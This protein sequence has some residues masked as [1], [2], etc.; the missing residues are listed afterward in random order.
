MAKSMGGN[1]LDRSHSIAVAKSGSIYLVGEYN[2][3]ADFDPG[4]ATFTLFPHPVAPIFGPPSEDA[5]I[6]KL[7]STGNFRWAFGFA[8][9]DHGIGRSVA[10]DKNE[11]VYFA[12]IFTHTID[13]DPGPATFNMTSTGTGQ[14]YD[15][16]I[17]KLDSGGNF[18]WAKQFGGNQG[19]EVLAMTLDDFG[20]IYTCGIF[21]TTADFDPGPN[22]FNLSVTPGVGYLDAFISKLDA[23][24]NFKWAKQIGGLKNELAFA[25]TSDGEGNVI[26]T[27]TFQDSADFD[28]GPLVYNLYAGRSFI[29]KLDSLGNFVWAKSLSGMNESK[30]VT[31]DLNGNVIVGGSFY[32]SC[33]F[34]PGVSNYVLNALVWDIF[35]TK[36][37]ADG[38]FI[39]AKGFV[40]TN[41]EYQDCITHDAFGNIYAGGRFS[42]TVDFDPGPATY[43]LINTN[44]GASKMYLLKLDANGNLRWAHGFGGI[45]LASCNSIAIDNQ[46]HVYATGSYSFTVDFNPSSGNNL[47]TS[48][49]F[50]DDVY[51]AKYSQCLTTTSQSI[52]AC[53]SFNWIDGNT[54]LTSNNTASITYSDSS[55]CD[56]IVTLNLTIINL[57]DSIIQS[58]ITL[59]SLDSNAS[60]QWLDC[61][62]AYSAII[63]A[64]SQSYIASTNGNY[65]LMLSLNGCVDTS[66]CYTII[67]VNIVDNKSSWG[68]I[69]YPNPTKG[70][71]NIYLSN[72]VKL[73]VALSLFNMLGE[74]VL[75]TEII[76][77]STELYL[78]VSVGIYFLRLQDDENQHIQKI[79]L[80][81]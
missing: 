43:N 32:G 47:L 64:T 48:T 27:G 2:D 19:D 18:I 59:T 20:N 67:G 8:G 1:G 7:D 68:S 62:N 57:N 36:L 81:R 76:K 65:A 6:T 71:I 66:S 70:K 41:T 23:N 72:N 46:G 75:E 33:D 35:I 34:D 40:G 51:V 5:F 77:T 29:S 49:L 79:V 50:T 45:A 58:G 37:D 54:Y 15:V 28:P 26:T 3:T 78:D 42:S 61:N 14:Q 22:T 73:P 24:G 16:F 63:G 80:E 13:F 56:S 60:Y 25:I 53:E 38:S 69:F 39:W 44:P 9:F 10:V 30:T 4:P 74:K 31:S 11:N 17:L 21:R 55:G 52:V 12:G